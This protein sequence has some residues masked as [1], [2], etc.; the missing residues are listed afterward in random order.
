MLQRLERRNHDIE[1][2]ALLHVLQRALER[3]AHDAERFRRK[4]DARLVE[5]GVERREAI[6]DGAHQGI[7]RQLHILERHARRIAAVDHVRASYRHAGRGGIDEEQAQAVFIARL[8]GR[9]RDDDQALRDVAVE[10]QPF[11]TIELPASGRTHSRRFDFA[12]V[13]ARSFFER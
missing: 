2:H 1:L 11:F 12:R 3:S 4:A 5:H 10:H 7:L 9:A 8:A 13:M 6:V